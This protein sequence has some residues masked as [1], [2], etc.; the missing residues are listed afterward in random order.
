VQYLAAWDVHRAVVF[1]RCEPHTGKAPFG[2]LVDQVMSQEPY[3][4]LAACSG[5][6]TTAH[7]IAASALLKS[8]KPVTHASSLCTR[9]CTPV[10]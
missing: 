10:G 7:L 3:R 1:G 8:Y 6:L 4:S 9:P 2:R 5:S